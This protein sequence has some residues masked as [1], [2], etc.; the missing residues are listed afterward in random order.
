MSKYVE[1]IDSYK[2]IFSNSRVSIPNLSNNFILKESSSSAK[3]K[4]IEIR[5]VPKNSILIDLDNINMGNYLKMVL[6]SSLGIFECCDYAII[7]LINDKIYCIFIE[8]KSLK[9]DV[10]H[11]TNQLKGGDCFIDYCNSI[12][13]NFLNFPK[14]DELNIQNRYILI[15]QK[16]FKRETKNRAS[17]YSSPEEFYHIGVGKVSSADI[18]FEKLIN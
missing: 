11:V 17:K 15:S 4:E 8:L 5:N 7:S 12:I 6:N 14:I 13:K 10:R 1:F 16:G 9:P 2:N 3:L 18:S